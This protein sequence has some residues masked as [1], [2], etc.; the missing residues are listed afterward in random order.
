MQSAR[1]AAWTTAARGSSVGAYLAKSKTCSYLRLPFLRVRRMS[2]APTVRCKIKAIVAALNT[3]DPLGPPS[4]ERFRLLRELGSGT[5][6]PWAALE[7]LPDG[8]TRLV[9][10]ERSLRGGT[11]TDQEIADWLH[12]AHLLTALEHPCVG[13]CARSS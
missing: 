3:P 13:G 6:P 7:L 12:D 2:K 4:K 11:Y 10:I 9:V 1:I 5:R 8:K